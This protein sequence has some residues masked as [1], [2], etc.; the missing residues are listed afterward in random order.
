MTFEYGLDEFASL[1]VR[2]DRIGLYDPKTT[3]R[4]IISCPV[5]KNSHRLVIAFV[6]DIVVEQLDITM[7]R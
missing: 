5:P 2:L 7:Y 6:V 4:N 3:V 1:L